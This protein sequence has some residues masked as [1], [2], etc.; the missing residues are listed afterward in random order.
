MEDLMEKI[1]QIVKN[2]QLYI[3]YDCIFY[4]VQD[5]DRGYDYLDRILDVLDEDN[6]KVM[7]RLAKWNKK[8][9][10]SKISLE[11]KLNSVY[12]HEKLKSMGAIYSIV[13]YYD[14]RFEPPTPDYDSY[15]D[16]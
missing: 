3:A 10:L 6:K 2:S 9:A 1:S 16:D 4:H 15:D 8:D 11:D 5:A 7:K 13:S 12:S 14:R